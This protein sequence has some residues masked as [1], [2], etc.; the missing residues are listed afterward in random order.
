[1]VLIPGHTG[2]FAPPIPP[3][4]QVYSMDALGGVAVTVRLAHPGVQIC[5]VLALMVK[6]KDGFW[7]EAVTTHILSIALIQQTQGKHPHRL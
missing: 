1:M 4:V 2:T 5:V 6:L 7:V 3:G